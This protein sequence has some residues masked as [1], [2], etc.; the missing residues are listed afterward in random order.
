MKLKRIVLLVLAS[1]MLAFPAT[2]ANAKSSATPT[3]AQFKALQKQVTK[4]QSQVKKLQTETNDLNAFANGLIPLLACQDVVTADALQGTW[5]VID[6]IST[7][8][9][10]G[11]VYF[12]PQT[13]LVDKG[14]CAEFR[15][16][17]SQSVPA[18]VSVFSS[19][20]TLLMS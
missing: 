17:R 15:I 6:Q 19:L 10:A 5:S 9:Q 11:K 1:A 2:Q 13:P 12:G 8:T 14:A 20:V 18:T 16:T 7:A 3:L 4:L